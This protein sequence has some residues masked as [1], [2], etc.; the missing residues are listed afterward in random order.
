MGYIIRVISSG[1][2]VIS[3]QNRA[4]MRHEI[5]IAGGG[6]ENRDSQPVNDAH[7]SYRSV[8]ATFQKRLS[9]NHL[10]YLV[11]LYSP[12]GVV[13]VEELRL[14]DGGVVPIRGGL[15]VGV[16]SGQ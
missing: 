6:Q 13:R 16:A 10:G 1:G 8:I 12:C 9:Q 14:V 2:T 3:T 7:K 4:A 15:L 11:A 5:S